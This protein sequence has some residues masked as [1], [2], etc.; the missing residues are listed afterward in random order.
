MQILWPGLGSIPGP[1]TRSSNTLQLTELDLT[2]RSCNISVP[3]PK[4]VA[5]R[6]FGT[7]TFVQS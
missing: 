3:R 1:L 7:K 2:L 4:Q 6:K 5:S